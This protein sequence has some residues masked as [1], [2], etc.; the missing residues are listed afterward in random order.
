MSKAPAYS[1][2]CAVSYPTPSHMRRENPPHLSATPD[3]D[4]SGIER[5]GAEASRDNNACA[6]A[7]SPLLS[8]CVDLTFLSRMLSN[9]HGHA[10][11]SCADITNSV[12]VCL[13]R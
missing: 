8:P 5:K 6:A 9:K 13:L 2:A 10:L 4:L 11:R 7:E 3:P 1:H 12:G